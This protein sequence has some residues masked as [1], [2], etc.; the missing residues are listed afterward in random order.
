MCQRPEGARLLDTPSSPVLAGAGTDLP[1]RTVMS[2]GRWEKGREIMI[3][4][5]VVPK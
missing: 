1:F 4:Q 3:N 5:L 2:D